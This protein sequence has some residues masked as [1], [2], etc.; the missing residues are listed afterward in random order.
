MKRRRRRAKIHEWVRGWHLVSFLWL[1]SITFSYLN[2]NSFGSRRSTVTCNMKRT[3]KSKKNLPLCLMNYS[4]TTFHNA[5]V[6]TA[7]C[8][9]TTFSSHSCSSYLLRWKDFSAWNGMLCMLC[10]FHYF[11][12]ESKK[13][14]RSIGSFVYFVTYCGFIFRQAKKDFQS[15]FLLLI[16]AGFKFLLSCDEFLTG[17]RHNQL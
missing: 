15:S 9:F 10:V 8:S 5:F 1:I 7:V 16:Y 6:V 4:T 14:H 12:N 2:F 11:L 17:W 3:E 13:K